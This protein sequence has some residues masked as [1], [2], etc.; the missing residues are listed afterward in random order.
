MGMGERDDDPDDTA[1]HGSG[2]DRRRF[3]VRAGVAGAAAW[4]APMVISRPAM[5]ATSA[6]PPTNPPGCVSCN[7][8]GIVNGSFEDGLDGWQQLGTNPVVTYHDA[9]VN[10]PFDAGENLCEVFGSVSQTFDIDDACVGRSFTLSFFVLNPFAN[11][12]RLQAVVQFGNGS[13]P[14][15]DPFV[16]A[17]PITSNTD[18]LPQSLPGFVPSGADRVTV[19]FRDGIAAID[20]VD[21][22]ICA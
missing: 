19:T 14:V 22:T 17:A 4:V 7:S 9:L 13:G 16:A 6:T 3:L 20:L 10:A 1:R 15:G 12:P 11:F 2:H 21:F 18:L 5:A 8:A